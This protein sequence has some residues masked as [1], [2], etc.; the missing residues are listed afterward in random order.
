MSEGFRGSSACVQTLVS[1]SHPSF[2]GWVLVECEER[3]VSRTFHVEINRSSLLPTLSSCIE[4]S[5]CH[6]FQFR[7]YSLGDTLQ[8]RFYIWLIWWLS[9]YVLQSNFGCMTQESGLSLLVVIWK[10]SAPLFHAKIMN[11]FV[12]ISSL[13]GFGIEIFLLNALNRIFSHRSRI[14]VIYFL[15]MPPRSWTSNFPPNPSRRTWQQTPRL[16]FTVRSMVVQQN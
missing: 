15:Q 13:I 1:T 12:I 14:S 9:G 3:A 5:S 4:R 6:S 16:S 2:M 10:F 7:W 8:V 11:S